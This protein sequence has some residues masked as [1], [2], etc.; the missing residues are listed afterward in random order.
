M[1]QLSQ[2][3]GTLRTE[4]LLCASSHTLFEAA[5]SGPFLAVLRREI[6]PGTSVAYVFYDKSPKEVAM[7]TTTIR[8]PG[9]RRTARPVRRPATVKPN[10][11]RH[12]MREAEKRNTYPKRP[13]Q[14]TRPFETTMDF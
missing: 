11:D 12:V 6:S 10:K 9:R 2:H 4:F 14:A 1:E 13:D 7:N 8:R 5:R 3:R